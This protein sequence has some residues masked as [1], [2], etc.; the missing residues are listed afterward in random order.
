MPPHG[1]S[2]GEAPDEEKVENKVEGAPLRRTLVI[3]N[4]RGLHARAAARFV[5]T[6]GAFDAKVSV[7]KDDTEVSGLS[8]MGLMMLAAGQGCEIELIVSGRQAAEAVEAIVGMV[9]GKLDEI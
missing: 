8:I 4:P 6:A 1:E 2:P 3:V 9:A 7:R 5:K